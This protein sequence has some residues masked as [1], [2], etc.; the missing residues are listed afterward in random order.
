MGTSE[1]IAILISEPLQGYTPK[2][3]IDL[4]EINDGEASLAKEMA[5]IN[6]KTGWLCTK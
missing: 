6:N 3:I 1:G 5:C 4:L 2:D